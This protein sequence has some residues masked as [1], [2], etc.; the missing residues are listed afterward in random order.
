LPAGPNI[1]IDQWACCSSALTLDLGAFGRRLPET[2]VFLAAGYR[3]IP[4]HPPR[5]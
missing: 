2:A 4:E 3:S 5:A 1:G